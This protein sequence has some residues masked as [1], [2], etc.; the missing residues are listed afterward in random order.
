MSKITIREIIVNAVDQSRLVNR[1]Q[2]IPG[3]IFVSAYTL[4]QRRLD[5]YSN[6]HLLSFI[7]KE[8]DIST[9]HKGLIKLGQYVLKEDYDGLVNI[10]EKEDDLPSAN[11]LNPGQ[12]VFVKET[13][14]GMRVDHVALNANAYITIPNADTWFESL[15]DYEIN[16]QEVNRVYAK[17]GDGYN[18]MNYIAYEDFY[19]RNYNTTC[20][21]VHVVSD[22]EQDLIIKEP[23]QYDELKLIYSEPFEFDV[24]TELNIPRQYIA[25]FTAALT[26]DLSMAY[27]RLGD[28]TTAML[29]QRL[30]ELEENV[31]RSSSIQKFI[32]RDVN[33]V[34]RMTR[35]EF[36][37]GQWLLD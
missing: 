10:Y 21:T 11:D 12:L 16:V 8:I 34:Y 6:T 17:F 5:Q 32:S 29:K 36:A 1:S 7:Q 28:A 20:Y 33:R 31:R 15:P 9:G 14:R 13:K 2:P 22:S 4:L 27:P 26:Y 23:T 24:D 18:E 19:N 37:G 30:D 35:S 3:N 25:L